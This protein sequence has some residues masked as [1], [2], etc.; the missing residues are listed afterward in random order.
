MDYAV[1]EIDG[2]I[3]V[4]LS[5]RMTLIDHGKFREV[6][7]SL[8][9]MRGTRCVFDLSKLEFVDS[10]GL[11]MFLI[12]R[13]IAMPKNVEIELRGA[14]EGVGR[15]LEIAKFATLFTVRG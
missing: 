14:T 6:V 2:G 8:E 7:D 13:D 1:Q 11:G 9:R 12:A 15:V 4:S 10:S 3:L 5:G